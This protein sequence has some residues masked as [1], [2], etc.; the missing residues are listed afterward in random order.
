VIVTGVNRCGAITTTTDR[1]C[2]RRTAPGERCVHHRGGP[3]R[4]PGIRRVE[5]AL[6]V[7]LWLHEQSESGADRDEISHVRFLL[8]QLSAGER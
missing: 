4:R 5:T 3:P 6:G 2:L 7:L 8:D 1:P